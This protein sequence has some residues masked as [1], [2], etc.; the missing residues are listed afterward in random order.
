MY[1]SVKAVQ[2]HM[3]DKGHCKM[4]HE[5]DAVFEYTDYYDYRSSYPDNEDKALDMA[6]GGQAEDE[7]EGEEYNVKQDTLDEEGYQLV[8]ASGTSVGHRSLQ[9]YYRQKLK[10]NRA[11]TAPHVGVSKVISQYK[12]LGWTG[13]TGVDVVRRAKDMGH[14]RRMK[15]NW[16]LKLGQKGNNMQKF[17]RDQVFGIRH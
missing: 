15:N 10:P 6:A 1:P 3:M 9:R 5:G 14:V 12:A 4:A 8:L 13:S 11:Y 2:Q 16:Y 7:D 17:F